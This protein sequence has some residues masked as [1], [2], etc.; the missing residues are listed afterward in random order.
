[1]IVKIYDKG[2]R[3]L[4]IEV[5]CNNARHI[6]GKHGVENFSVMMEKFRQILESFIK[7]LQ[8]SHVSFIDN[9]EFDQ[10]CLPSK[11][12]ARPLAGIDFNKARCRNAIK[13]VVDLGRSPGRIL[14]PY[15]HTAA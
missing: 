6:K 4:R 12:G 7:A 10:L 11:K 14:F 13:V 5:T 2:E 8:L 1:M 3:V 9:G 15:F